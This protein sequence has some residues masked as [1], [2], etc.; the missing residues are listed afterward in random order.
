MTLF[1]LVAALVIAALVGAIIRDLR[2]GG[3]NWSGV[4]DFVKAQTRTALH[5]WGERKKLAPGSTLDNL[6]RMS[7]GLSAALLLVLALT[8]FL[9]VLLLGDHVSGTLLIIHVTAAPL[10]AIC[11][12][13]FALLWAHRLRFDE[14]D[15]HLVLNPAHRRSSTRSQRIRFALKAG[16]WLVLVISLPLMGS[17]ILGLFPIFG[18]GGQE[19]LIRTHGYSALLIFVAA[20]LAIHVTIAYVQH[21]SEQTSKESRQ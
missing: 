10:F 18:T 17:I 3:R 6:R 14:A 19:A 16:F 1:R 21:T 20:V 11:L 4:W 13:A 5:L 12:S 7:Y 8:G 2:R 15:W 9:P